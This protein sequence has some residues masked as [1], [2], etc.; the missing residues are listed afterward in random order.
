MAS[1]WGAMLPSGAAGHGCPWPGPVLLEAR[2]AW[3]QS[4]DPWGVHGPTWPDLGLMCPQGQRRLGRPAGVGSLEGDRQVPP[5]PLTGSGRPSA[6][7]PLWPCPL[8]GPF[9]SLPPA[10]GPLQDP[11]LL[12]LG[13]LPGGP[14]LTALLWSGSRAQ[15]LHSKARPPA[16]SPGPWVGHTCPILLPCSATASLGC[17]AS[18]WGLEE[19]GRAAEFPWNKSQ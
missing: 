13:P 6:S 16:P 17:G 9:L 7:W 11:W 8:P 15:G 19:P 10:P 4:F 2:T 3:G 18:P 1:M 12:L 5:V 14:L